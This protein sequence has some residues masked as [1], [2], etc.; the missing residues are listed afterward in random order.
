MAWFKVSAWGKL[1][2]VCNLYL[3]KGSQV[4]V[5]GRLIV[6]QETG[7]PRIWKKQ[8]GNLAANFEINANLS[9]SW[10]GKFI[11]GMARWKRAADSS[12][13]RNPVSRRFDKSISFSS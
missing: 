3:K 4:Y 10:A 9:A 2:E 1:A 6:D 12:G 13:I 11:T 5:E 8:D 7:G